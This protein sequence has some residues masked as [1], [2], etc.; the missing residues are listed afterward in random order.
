MNDLQMTKRGDLAIHN[1]DIMT[2][3][4]IE[5]AILIKLRWFFS[6]WIYN[7]NLGIEWFEKV[8]IKN[9]NKLL[10]RRMIEDAVLSVDGVTEVSDVKLTVYN[11]T[12]TASIS[13]RYKTDQGAEDMME[14]IGLAVENDEL[15]ATV[16]GSKL[17]L[18]TSGALCYV[19]DQTMVFT[20]Y[21]NVTVKEDGDTATLVIGGTDGEDQSN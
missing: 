8:L 16:S 7:T 21:A 12:R 1:Y 17:H 9:P 15:V 20:K 6:E 11:E 3:D 10:V 19:K 5:Q 2:T 13:F 14:T 4:S 18:E